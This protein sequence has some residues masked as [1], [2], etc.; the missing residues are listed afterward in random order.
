[1]VMPLVPTNLK[2][3]LAQIYNL[4]DKPGTRQV[5]AA[6]DEFWLLG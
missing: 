3:S 5:V 2:D 4:L 1:M 6:L